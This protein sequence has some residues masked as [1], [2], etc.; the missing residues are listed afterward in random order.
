MKNVDEVIPRVVIRL[1]F[2]GE[3]TVMLERI[4]EKELNMVYVFEKK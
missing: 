1:I 2:S 4:V 3:I